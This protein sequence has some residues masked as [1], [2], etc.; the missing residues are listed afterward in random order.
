[1]YMST[2]HQYPVI[3][4][5]DVVAAMMEPPGGPS[6]VE[7]FI[8]GTLDFMPCHARGRCRAGEIFAIPG[9]GTGRTVGRRHLGASRIGSC[10]PRGAGTDSEIAPWRQYARSQ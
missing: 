1:M 7:D 10:T 3:A 9:L 2:S 5:C 6:M 8:L 4:F